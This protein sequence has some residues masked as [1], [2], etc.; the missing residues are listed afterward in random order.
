M[1]LAWWQRCRVTWS[2][3]PRAHGSSFERLS[4][5]NLACNHRRLLSNNYLSDLIQYRDVPSSAV[6]AETWGDRRPELI[7][8]SCQWQQE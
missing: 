5:R 6:V 3:H 1:Q 7:A 4:R 8:T 2:S